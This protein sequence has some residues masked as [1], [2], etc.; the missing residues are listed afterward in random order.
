MTGTSATSPLRMLD[1]SGLPDSTKEVL[2]PVLFEI[3]VRELVRSAQPP[4]STEAWREWFEF[5]D[6]LRPAAASGSYRDILD[7]SY[8]PRA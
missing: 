5:C 7:E 8:P 2:R 6:G 3:M 4:A 1:F